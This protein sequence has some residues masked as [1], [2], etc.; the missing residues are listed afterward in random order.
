[1]KLLHG[2]RND[3]DFTVPMPTNQLFSLKYQRG[4]ENEYPIPDIT[5]KERLH[6][7][8]IASFMIFL[9]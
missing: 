6:A 4:I 7:P 2:F 3:D 5:K 1:M 9:N 8:Q